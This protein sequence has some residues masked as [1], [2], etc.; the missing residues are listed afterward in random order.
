MVNKVLVEGA[1]PDDAIKETE[2]KLNQIYK[3]FNP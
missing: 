1:S 3:Q 2:E